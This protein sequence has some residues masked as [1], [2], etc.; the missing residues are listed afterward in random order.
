MLL[1][2]LLEDWFD[3]TFQAAEPATATG[4]IG[5][6]SV[7]HTQQSVC[8]YSLFCQ[9]FIAKLKHMKPT[10][11]DAYPTKHFFFFFDSYHSCIFV[12]DSFLLSLPISVTKPTA[13]SATMITTSGTRSGP[14]IDAKCNNK[15]THT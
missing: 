3:K 14:A 15:A 13:I 12:P 5:G 11:P 4:D 9:H 2:M 10:T 6:L 1:S 8:P 7:E